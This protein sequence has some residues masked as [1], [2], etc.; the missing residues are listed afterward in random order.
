MKNTNESN[1]RAIKE[2]NFKDFEEKLKEEAAKQSFYL[3]G[4]R[5]YFTQAQMQR[6]FE[7]TTERKVRKGF[8]YCDYKS[9]KKERCKAKIN[10]V[11]N[12]NNKCYLTSKIC[13]QHNHPTIINNDSTGRQIISKKKDLTEEDNYII[14]L[15]AA[16]PVANRVVCNVLEKQNKQR[17][18]DINL[19]NRVG[20]C[21][22]NKSSTFD[23]NT[24]LRVFTEKIKGSKRI[25]RIR[26]N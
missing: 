11:Y 7:S 24:E 5:V 1:F 16:E 12:K 21:I 23:N 10:F 20:K 9:E 6:H 3:A 8:F 14:N 15:L 22:R 26:C 4:S 25:Q 2:E 17:N 13:L 18:Y 19:I